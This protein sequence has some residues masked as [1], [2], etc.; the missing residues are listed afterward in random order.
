MT[1]KNLSNFQDL[2]NYQTGRAFES[3]NRHFQ[4]RKEKVGKNTH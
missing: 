2:Q 4:N 3:N 1:S